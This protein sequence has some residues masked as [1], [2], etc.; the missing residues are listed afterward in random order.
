VLKTI[1]VFSVLA[2]SSAYAQFG[3]G[4]KLGVPATDAFEV[5]QTES[6][7]S[8]QH[9]TWG[10]WVELRLPANNAIEL[11]ALHRGYDY[12]PSG[13]GSSWEFPL[14]WKHRIGKQL[15]KPY[16]EGGAAFSRLSDINLDTLK[17]RSNFGIVVGGGLE[18]N[19]LLFKVFPEVRYTGWTI[20]NF[21]GSINTNKNQFAVLVG[22]G[23]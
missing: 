21:Q 4:I 17:H 23:F 20:D 10:P 1:W 18:F 5:V 13:D 3:F 16:F 19:L 6:V 11:D 15:I 2:A 12:G 8:S 9:F 14:V 7:A 22:F